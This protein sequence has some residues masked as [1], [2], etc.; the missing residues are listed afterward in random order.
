MSLLATSRSIPSQLFF[1]RHGARLDQLETEWHLTSPTPYDPPLTTKGIAQARLTGL[2]IKDSL[3]TTGHLRIILHT[4]P[5]LRCVQTALSLA[6]ALGKK[7]LFRVDAWLG[8]WLTPDYYTDIDPPPP[9]K[10]LCD[11]ALAG[12]IGR[13]DGVAVDWMWDTL[14]FGDGGEYGEEWGSMHERLNRGLQ[15]LLQYYEDEPMIGV[16]NGV[17]GNKSEI[18]NGDGVDAPIQ[19]IVILVTHG[20]GCNA[21][22]GALTRKPVLTDIPLTSLSMAVLRPTTPSS[23]VSRIEYDMVLQASADHLVDSPSNSSSSFSLHSRQTSS[24]SL[25]SPLIPDK[26]ILEYHQVRTRSYSSTSF[27][28]PSMPSTYQSRISDPRNRHASFNLRTRSGLFGG[29][30]R[31]DSSRSGLWSP[32]SP[33]TAVSDDE[34]D[35][36]SLSEL[37]TPGQEKKSGGLWRSW[38]GQ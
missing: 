32:S 17:N 7:V 6:A 30:P 13:T 37:G 35:S 25:R 10:Q 12:L 1:L 8:E 18:S 27:S 26:R 2:A 22:L 11:S 3:P 34:D 15:R 36:E 4:S 28:E 19:T 16:S 14:K 31:T 33:S 5:F 24:P 21:L 20:A 9:G 29:L 38:S 23:T